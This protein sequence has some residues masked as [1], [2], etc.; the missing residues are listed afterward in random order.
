MTTTI[1]LTVGSSIILEGTLD[2]PSER[3]LPPVADFGEF[4]FLKTRDGRLVLLNPDKSC[5]SGVETGYGGLV[6]SYSF[7]PTRGKEK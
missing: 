7:K 2:S 4:A 3:I 5:V 1:L 6:E